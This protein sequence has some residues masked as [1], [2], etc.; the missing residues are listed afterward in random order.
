MG[1]I[2]TREFK[3]R[4]DDSLK[5]TL[6]VEDERVTLTDA[7][8]V[9][10]ELTAQQSRWLTNELNQ[11][12][13]K[14]DKGA[15]DNER[16]FWFTGHVNETSVKDMSKE[17]VRMGFKELHREEAGPKYLVV[18]INSHGGTCDEGFAL[19]GAIEFVRGLGIPVLGI[20]MGAAMSMGICLLQACTRRTIDRHAR[21]MVHQVHGGMGGAVD[22]MQAHLD[23][24]SN[25]NNA[26][27]ALFAERNPG[28]VRGKAS[29]WLKL[30]KGQDKHFNAEECI[31]MG[32]ADDIFNPSEFYHLAE[33]MKP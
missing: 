32:M 21:I 15:L 5:V 24:A 25:I 18:I 10:I 22:I 13:G 6:K 19:I 28:S 1:T 3:D 26:I 27:A 12:I 23:Q 17:L 33:N 29:Y 7:A 14:S 9:S 8:S 16:I 31:K 11:L 4:A 30:F 2:I 20:V